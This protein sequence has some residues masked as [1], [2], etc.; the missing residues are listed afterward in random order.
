MTRRPGILVVEMAAAVAILAL[1]LTTVAAL[2]TRAAHKRQE[3]WQK[4]VAHECLATLTDEIGC[5]SFEQTTP[6]IA[7]ATAIPAAAARQLPQASIQVVVKSAASVTAD[8][9]D[10]GA[11]REEP[12]CRVVFVSLSWATGHGRPQATVQT[13]IWK[14]P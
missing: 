9:G 10:D 7:A 3:N 11:G 14:F 6:A 5:W 4:L 2:A 1:V 8:S 12:D 13:A